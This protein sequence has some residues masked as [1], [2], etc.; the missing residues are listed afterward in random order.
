[1]PSGAKIQLVIDADSKRAEASLKAFQAEAKSAGASVSKLDQAASARHLDKFEEKLSRN[2]K[3]AKYF[4]G[5]TAALEKSKQLLRREIERLIRQGMD[6]LDSTVTRLKGRYDSNTAALQKLTSANR[7]YSATMKTASAVTGTFMRSVLPFVGMTAAISSAVS[8]IRDSGEAFEESEARAQKFA[9]TYE[10]ITDLATERVKKLADTFNYADSTMMGILAETGDL[11][12]GF[13]LAGVE[14]LNLTEKAAYL[15]AALAKLNPNIGDAAAATS[16]LTKLMSGEGESMKKWGVIVRDSAVQAKLLEQG[17]TGL[18]GEALLQA[19][20]Q[21]R[22]EIAYSQS[23]NALANVSSET[24]LALDVA[25]RYDE[26]WKERK[27]IIGEVT[28]NFFT[29]IKLKIAEQIEAWNEATQAKKNYD[30]ALAGDPTADLSAAIARQQEKVDELY[31]DLESYANP[32]N[33]A[34]KWFYGGADWIREAVG[35]DTIVESV[36]EKIKAEEGKLQQLKDQLAEQ[37]AGAECHLH[38]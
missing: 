16:D 17:M 11:L 20:A 28:S 4:G 36:L 24:V 34:K 31:Q 2:A 7:A 37:T 22:L 29:P 5:E 6:P 30:A 26:A 10:G 27:E 1:M 23:K 19:Q 25:R 8:M 15:G 3:A 9:I 18:S 33:L 35:G 32:D 38:Y 21:A 14:A 13:G 12:T